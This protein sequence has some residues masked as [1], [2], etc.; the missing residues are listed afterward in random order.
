[1]APEGAFI[2]TRTLG[3]ECVVAN[4]VDLQLARVWVG[5]PMRD[6]AVGVD[7]PVGAGRGQLLPQGDDF[8]GRHHR[9][10]PAVEGDHLGLDL[11]LRQP[12]RIEEAMEA[13]RRGHVSAASSEVERAHAA[14]AIAGDDD[15]TRSTS[16]SPRVRAEHVSEAP[17]KCLTVALQPVELAEH[18]VAGRAT[19]L[20]P[21]DVGDQRIIAEL[22]QLPRE[23]DLEVGDAHDRRDQDHGRTR[24]AVTPAD[25]HAL[26]LLAFEFVRNR[27][28]LAH[29]FSLAS[30]A[31]LATVFMLRA[32]PCAAAR[33]CSFDVP[34]PPG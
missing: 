4:S 26:Q 12:G 16:S 25:E 33:I 20:L 17:A 14:E 29:D 6:V 19:E 11:L 3:R 9:I 13:H 21:E 22:D 27:A 34:W 5:E 31:S 7:L 23:P 15:L 1:M 28:V 18:C 30:S 8:L 2:K 32:V 24:L 10:V